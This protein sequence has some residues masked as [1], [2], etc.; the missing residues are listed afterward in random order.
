MLRGVTWNLFLAVIP[1]LLGLVVAWGLRRRGKDP[2][3][4]IWLTL[5]LML[6]WLA[7]LPN[8]CYLLTEW[9]H[10]LYDQRW[11][12]LLDAG[13][14]DAG[15]M[16]SVARWS[17]F[18][19]LYSAAGVLTFGLAVRPVDRALR[20]TGFR[21]V[22]AAP[23]LFF[24]VALGVYLGLRARFNS[25]DFVTDPLPIW[26]RTVGA[27][28]SREVLSAVAAFG[29]VLW[30]IYLVVDVW[31]EGFLARLRQLGV[32]GGPKG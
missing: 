3:L 10:L 17:L 12:R 22:L 18:F 9:R 1:V 32:I 30:L 31:V 24:L 14:Q 4:P 13:Q 15:A 25:W 28:R 5:P 7:F 16:L 8:T 20:S 11:A 29:G 19:L 6:V 2:N 27:F 26:E 23:F 21:P